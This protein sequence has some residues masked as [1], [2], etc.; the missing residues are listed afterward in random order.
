MGKIS[1]NILDNCDTMYDE[2]DV[3]WIKATDV[4]AIVD[5]YKNL[6]KHVIDYG[7]P[8]GT[9]AGDDIAEALKMIDNE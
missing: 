3:L 1:V 4:T 6:V 7:F 5:L 9:E 8:D 2:F